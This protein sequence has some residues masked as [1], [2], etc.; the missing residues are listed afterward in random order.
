MKLLLFLLPFFQTEIKKIHLEGRA[1]GTTWLVNYYAT[2]T[3][4]TRSQID[5]IFL[6]IDSSLSLYKS[7]SLINQ[8]NKSDSGLQVDDHFITV[9]RKSV[10]V[11]HT[12]KGAFDIT[13]GAKCKGSD[14]LT[15]RGNTL[16]KKHPCITIDV[17]GIA[18]GY[19]VDVIA[20]FLLQK[21]I[22]DFI[23]ELGGEIRAS[24]RK[25]P[26]GE[27]MKI[28]IESPADNDSPSPFIQKII[29]LESGA[30]TTSG[31]YNKK[32]H[33]ID[34]SSGKP[35]NNELV[36]VTVYARDAVTAD[37][38]D[39]AFMVFGLKKALR[40]VERRKDMAAYFI[41]RKKNGQFAA[42]ASKR[43]MKLTGNQ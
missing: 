25:Q 42:I 33:I 14:G 6:R 16:L 39:N 21:N 38:Y 11:Y 41:Y 34:P 28:G 26:A 3:I 30:I 29:S 40:F 22:T 27:T 35:V 12:T 20:E 15:I 5:S 8:F 13:Y 43:F 31:N 4:V 18:Q 10:D 17:N 2:D 24:G 7:Y 37:A 32:D 19:S 23:I 9:I 1:Q 36:S